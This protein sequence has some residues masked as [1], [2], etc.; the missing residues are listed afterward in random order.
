MSSSKKIKKCSFIYWIQWK[1]VCWFFWPYFRF[2]AHDRDNVPKKGGVLIAGNHA[3]FLDPP[4]I[5]F[6]GPRPMH[7]LARSTLFTANK[8][9]GWYL[10]SIHCHE[11]ERDSADI[12]AMRAAL[13]ML[14][15]GLATVVFPEGTRTTTGRLRSAKP[16]IGWI[17]LHS[18][19]P[20][21]P[22]YLKGTYQLWPKGQKKPKP[23]RIDIY[24]GK[25]I[26]LSDLCAEKKIPREN[27]QIATDRIMAALSQMEAKH[28]PSAEK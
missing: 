18:R 14:E 4:L 23:G 15:D 24:F 25:P 9:W 13:Q 2:H 26:D 28:S 3:S 1:I 6:V 22:T 11:I 21:V 10:R 17:A 5:G 12:R 7:Y 27:Y 8:F 19:C 20:V 16:G